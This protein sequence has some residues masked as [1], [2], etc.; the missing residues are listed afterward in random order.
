MEIGPAD[1]VEELLEPLMTSALAESS[2]QVRFERLA[3][4]RVLLDFGL[5]DT[6]FTLTVEAESRS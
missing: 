3:A 1:I 6:V 4:N 5:P 2:P